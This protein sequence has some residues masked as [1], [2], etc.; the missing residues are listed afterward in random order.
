MI[1][2]AT[3]LS[4]LAVGALA[5]APS[6]ASAFHG[7]LVNCAPTVGVGV[8]A[9]LSPG[10]VCTDSLNKLTFSATGKTGNQL[11]GCAADLAAPWASWSAAKVASKITAADAA[12]IN[13]ADVTIKATAFG[14]CMLSGDATTYVPLAAGAGKVTFYAADGAT[15]VKGGANQ[16]YAR[17]AAD[18]PT[19]S[20]LAIGLVTKGLGAGATIE[21]QIGIDLA[22]TSQCG[23]MSCL[24]LIVGC[25]AGA[26]CPPDVFAGGQ[27][28]ITTLDLKTDPNSYL[29]I[30][31]PDN[32][33][34]TGPS[35][36]LHCCTGAGTGTC[37]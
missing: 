6:A 14:P 11:D 28:P 24:E 35:T 15:K 31:I 9:K 20:A 19:Q 17:I 27:A 26:I 3:I 4:A 36:P 37:S 30:A 33:D 10:L 25:N 18:L 29:R 2:G 7:N 34:C 5:L 22:G 1:K 23:T 12:L 13:K 8:P 32:A 16:F 21:V